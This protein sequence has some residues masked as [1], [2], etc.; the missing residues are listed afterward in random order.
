MAKGDKKKGS[1]SSSNDQCQNCDTLQE[2]LKTLQETNKSLQETVKRLT[3]RLNSVEETLKEL[4]AE[5]QLDSSSSSPI[6]SGIE[7]RI[8]QLEELVEERTNRQLRKT[9]F[10]KGI[11]ESDQEKSW[12]DVE[13]THLRSNAL[14]ESLRRS[15]VEGKEKEKLFY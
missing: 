13:T 2:L 9:L 10:I 7:E 3:D 1:S 15:F 4:T 5:K 11:A 14:V 6:S 12:F 8:I